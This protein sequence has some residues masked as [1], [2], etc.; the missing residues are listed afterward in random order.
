MVRKNRKRGERQGKEREGRM[1]ESSGQR[2]IETKQETRG[3][4]KEEKQKRLRK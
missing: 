3:V 2:R 4:E 1:I